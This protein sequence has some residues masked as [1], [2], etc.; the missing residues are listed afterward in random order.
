MKLNI[1]SFLLATDAPDR[2]E[3]R[4]NIILT[5]REMEALNAGCPVGFVFSVASSTSDYDAHSYYIQPPC[6]RSTA[7][8]FI[9]RKEES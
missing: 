9:Q 1:E 6:I 4:T 5:E 8:A 2:V 7:L 3:S